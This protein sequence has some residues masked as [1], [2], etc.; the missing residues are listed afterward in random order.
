MTLRDKVDRILDAKIQK[1]R[2]TRLAQAFASCEVGTAKFRCDKCDWESD[3]GELPYCP[4]CAQVETLILAAEEH[5]KQS[6]PD[7]EVGDLQDMLRTCWAFLSIAAKRKVLDN[8]RELISTWLE[9]K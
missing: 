9:G 2:E 6:E 1:G 5:G 7:H 8:H 3:I 4:A